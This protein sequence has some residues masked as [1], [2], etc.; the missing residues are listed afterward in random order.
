MTE[1]VVE[2]S[3]PVLNMTE[4]VVE[5]SKNGYIR[6]NI[7]DSGEVFF[8][9]EDNIQKLKDIF[10]KIVREILISGD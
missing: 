6:T 1:R 10:Y 4:R 9:G 3:L 8:V 2:V 7:I 5:V